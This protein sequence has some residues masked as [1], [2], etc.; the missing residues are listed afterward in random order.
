MEEETINTP[1]FAQLD[2]RHLFLMTERLTR[3]VLVGEANNSSIERPFKILRL[4]VFAP[5]PLSQHHADYGVRIYILED[6]Q[7]ALEV[8]QR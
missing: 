7:A 6:T 1:V 5:L 4:A 2:E 8:R 3:F